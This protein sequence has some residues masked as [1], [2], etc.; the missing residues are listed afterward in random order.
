[1]ACASRFELNVARPIVRAASRIVSMLVCNLYVFTSK[2]R[3]ESRRRR[4]GA[5]ATMRQRISNVS[6]GNSIMRRVIFQHVTEKA[7]P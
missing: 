2:R 7:M 3:D 5:R 4:P 6:T 1:M